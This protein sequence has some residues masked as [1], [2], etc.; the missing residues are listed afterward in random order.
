[1]QTWNSNA[2]REYEDSQGRIRQGGYVI[3]SIESFARNVAF[4]KGGGALTQLDG[5]Y[6]SG[7]D[8]LEA[9]RVAEAAHKSIETGA[10]VTL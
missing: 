4:I 6:P 7:I 8:G 10:A 3:E 1:M 2:N 5:H 9:T